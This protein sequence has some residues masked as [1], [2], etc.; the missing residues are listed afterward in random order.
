VNVKKEEGTAMKKPAT[1]DKSCQPQVA[2]QLPLPLL[3][4]L[5]AVKEG[6]FELCIRVG[7]QALDALM[8]QDRTELCGTKWSRDPSRRAVRGGS[9]SSEITLGGRRVSVRRLRASS[10]DGQELALP[11]FAWAAD[12]D[13]LDEQTWRS[14][15]AGVSTRSYAESLDPLPD[16]LR[17][18]STSSSSVSRRFVAL[19]QRQLTKCLSRPLGELDLWVVMIDGID[20]RDHAILVAMGIDSSGKKHVLGVREGTTENSAVAGALL[21][22]LVDRGLAT[23]HPLLFVIDGG[24]ALRKAI[25]RVF[26]EFGVVGRCQVHKMRNVLEHLPEEMRPSV[27]QAMRQAYAS[28]KPQSARRQ[29]ERL[30]RSLESDHPGAAASLREGL[31]E[32]LTLQAL[33]IKG[34]LWKTL[35]ST[36]PIENLNGGIAKFTRNVRRWRDGS[37]ILRWVGSAILEAEQKFRRVRG[38]REMPTLIEALRSR[39]EDKEVRRGRNVA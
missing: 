5:K 8:E 20:Y 18:R 38:Y 22:D 2:I 1:I 30:T 24:K 32:T 29:L 11:S 15:V 10:V 16:E 4:R 13:P 9:T 25:R 35:R 34:A 31:E 23:D 27:R 12:R 39:V 3:S 36:N 14:M 17:E 6:F 7:E 21:S 33:G 28:F 37:M 19:S 26:G